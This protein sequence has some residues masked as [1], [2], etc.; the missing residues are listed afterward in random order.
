M[1]DNQQDRLKR[2]RHWKSG[3]QFS[4][5]DVATALSITSARARQIL[6]DMRSELDI[7]KSKQ[8]IRYK[9]RST[10]HTLAHKLA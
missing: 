4:C 10:T 3:E 5:N 6:S 2:T 1:S 7:D 9:R 8:T